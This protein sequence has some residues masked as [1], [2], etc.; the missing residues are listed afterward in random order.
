MKL[1]SKMTHCGVRK[2]CISQWKLEI[3]LNWHIRRQAASLSSEGAWMTWK[4]VYVSEEDDTLRIILVVLLLAGLN[5][6]AIM[7]QLVEADI[8]ALEDRSK[9]MNKQAETLVQSEQLDSDDTREKRDSVSS[10]YEKHELFKSELSSHKPAIQAVQNTGKQLINIS[11]LGGVE[12][13]QRLKQRNNVWLEMKEMAS[14]HTYQQSLPKTE[15]EEEEEEDDNSVD[16][17]PAEGPEL[18][19]WSDIQTDHLVTGHSRVIPRECA[20]SA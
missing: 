11:Q 19:K 12:I 5:R 8:I 18:Q 17:G 15:E 1:E 3:G 6:A 7:H 20:G 14:N 16:I 4:Y 2:Q 9:D 13:E 10:Q